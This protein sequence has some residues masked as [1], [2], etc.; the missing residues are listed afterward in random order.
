MSSLRREIA[1]LTQVPEILE[2]IEQRVA[3]ANR[4]EDRHVLRPHDV[5]DVA[6]RAVR[7]GYASS[8]RPSPGWATICDAVRE[9]G[10]VYLDVQ[11][12]QQGSP[13]GISGWDT[14]VLRRDTIL[15]YRA[16]ACG[17]ARARSIVPLQTAELRLLRQG[18]W[19]PET[20]AGPWS[21][22]RFRGALLVRFRDDEDRQVFD[23]W[24][25]SRGM[26]GS[27]LPP[28]WTL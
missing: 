3:E 22:V 1:M 16:A 14:D 9:H 26:P 25:A 4:G 10:R 2:H 7:K 8:G 20:E 5:L 12:T 18:L 15:A 13:L 19:L 23:D 11:R 17:H 27:T 6:Q 24:R 28:G 21:G